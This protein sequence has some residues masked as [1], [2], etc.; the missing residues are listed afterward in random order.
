MA[1][2]NGPNYRSSVRGNRHTMEGT[3]EA[4]NDVGSQTSGQECTRARQLLVS[5][6]GSLLCLGRGRPRNQTVVNGCISALHCTPLRWR[7]SDSRAAV[8][9]CQFLSTSCKQEGA[10]ATVCAAGLHQ[11][12]T[13]VRLLEISFWAHSI[14]G[15]SGPLCHA[16]SLLLSLWTSIL[17]CHS[18]LSHAACAI[19]I[20]GFGSSW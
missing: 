1:A 8:A 18:L 7:I 19:A 9:C 20:A 14:W 10:V 6:I 17:H 5:R 15:H 12:N 16:L 2:W 4:A 13:P 3:S 11:H